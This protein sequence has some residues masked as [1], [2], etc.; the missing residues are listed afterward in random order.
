MMS[1]AAPETPERCENVP[2]MTAPLDVRHVIVTGLDSHPS[3]ANGVHNVARQI[4]RE[5]IAAGGQARIMFVSAVPVPDASAGEVPTEVVRAVGTTVL[6]RVIRLQS[7]VVS[8]LVADAGPQTVFH[9]HGGREPLLV[10]L[11]SRLRRRGI[12]YVVTVHGR[13]SHVYDQSDHSQRRVTALYLTAVERL[14][15]ANARF[16]HAISQHERRVLRRIAPRAQIQTIGHGAYSSRFDECPFGRR[17]GSDHLP[18]R[19]SPI[20]AVMQYGTRASICCSKAL[21]NTGTMGAAAP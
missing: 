4:A 5:Q 2:V 14:L 18:F 12:P 7:T 9:I 10:D 17:V 20:A 1:V 19:G 8:T 3:L 13:Y 21:P 6:R 16:V 11:A 15:L